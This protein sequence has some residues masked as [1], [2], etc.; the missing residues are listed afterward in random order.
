MYIHSII[1]HY[2]I[3]CITQGARLLY[4]RESRI[5]IDYNNL[6]DNLTDVSITHSMI[7]YSFLICTVYDYSTVVDR[8]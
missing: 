7:L 5:V 6:D 2:P 4:E 3:A 1:M 8:I